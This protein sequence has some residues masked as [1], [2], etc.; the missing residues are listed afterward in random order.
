MES[1]ASIF[2]RAAKRKGGNAAL[3]D[4][5]SPPKTAAQLKKVPDSEVLA[6]MTKCVFRSGFVWRII[7]NKWPGFVA[8]FH[9]F[10]VSS[11]AMLSDE[12]LEALQTDEAIVRHGK[13]IRSVRENAKYILNVREEHGGYG[14]FL[15]GWPQDDFVQLWAHLKKGGDRLGGQT[16]RFF[17]RFI[18][19]DTPM[20]SK[21]VVAAL[22]AAKV[23]EKEP[24]SQKA[25]QATQEAFNTWRAESGR[26]YN[27]IS[28]I[29]ACSVPGVRD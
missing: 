18:G 16:G 12:D 1:L 25:L 7:D 20:L 3:E 26:S 23:V 22:V 14:K 4:L 19:R 17:L 10:D 28:R 13:K 6:E 8:A 9:K 11:C 24:T 5:L 2:D 29:L 21:D 15:A 27:E